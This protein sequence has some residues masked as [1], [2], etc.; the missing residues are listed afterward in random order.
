MVNHTSSPK[1]KKNTTA[2]KESNAKITPK[3]G[4]FNKFFGKKEVARQEM[5]RKMTERLDNIKNSKNE[6]PVQEVQSVAEELSNAIEGWQADIMEFEQETVEVLEKLQE[7]EE[8]RLSSKELIKTQSVR[9]LLD[10]AKTSKNEVETREE[11]KQDNIGTE[12]RADTDLVNQK[13]SEKLQAAAE[14]ITELQNS[15]YNLEA[16]NKRLEVE[17]KNLEDKLTAVEEE[18]KALETEK[19]NLQN[20]KANLQ[21]NIKGATK[22]AGIVLAAQKNAI[23]SKNAVDSTNTKSTIGLAISIVTAVVS[24]VGQIPFFANFLAKYPIAQTLSKILGGV[25]LI[26]TV[27]TT[28]LTQNS[29]SVASTK[30]AK[31]TAELDE[32]QKPLESYIGG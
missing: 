13:I 19:A 3:K 20:E 27:V 25:G 10:L 26:G 18:K 32:A 8:K 4:F 31:F 23:V 17:K 22:K 24:G 12:E 11:S 21:N 16:N 29:A 9:F 30:T 1:T 2:Q 6:V 28:A 14:D 5:I 15:N 7:E